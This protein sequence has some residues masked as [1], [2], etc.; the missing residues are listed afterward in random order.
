MAP[1]KKPSPVVWGKPK[2][3][4]KPPQPD[5]EIIPA[6]AAAKA[7][8]ASVRAKTPP[9]LKQNV[10]TLNWS[11]D[12]DRREEAMEREEAE[13]ILKARKE[14]LDAINEE[15]L[16]RRT[17]RKI[18]LSFGSVGLKLLSTI[19]K[20]ADHLDVR[21]DAA[22]NISTKELRNIIQTAGATVSKAQSAIESMARAERFIARNPLE[23][24]DEEVDDLADLNSEQALLLLTNLSKQLGHIAEK[25]PVIDM[26]AEPPKVEDN[27]V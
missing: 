12:Y 22:D 11:A 18:A 4:A 3:Q 15:V 2:V 26:P 5:Q 14:R 21:L 7:A 16:V 8:L 23:G 9:L 13:A 24:G 6:P 1:T 27:E 17:N 19:R 25:H 10:E 20:A